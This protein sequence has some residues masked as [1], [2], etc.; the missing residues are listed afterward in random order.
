MA[1]M[2]AGRIQQTGTPREL[3][4][5]PRSRFVAEFL[6]EV[7]WYE[8]MGVRP[9]D[10][11]IEHQAPDFHFQAKRCVVTNVWYLGNYSR[12]E[13]RLD[14]GEVFIAQISAASEF[15]KPGEAVHVWWEK[16]DELSVAAGLPV[17]VNG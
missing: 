11:Q 10:L 8:G 6:G 2:D 9:E 15:Y 13:V 4:R 5:E 12:V 7:N 17:T 1:V 3:Y 14:S 16:A